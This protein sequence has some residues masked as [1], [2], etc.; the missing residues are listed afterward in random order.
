MVFSRTIW[1]GKIISTLATVLSYTVRLSLY[2][3]LCLTIK[4]VKLK[5]R[6]LPELRIPNS[7][8]QITF[9][10]DFWEL[11]NRSVKV[12]PSRRDLAGSNPANCNDFIFIYSLKF[13]L[14]EKKRTLDYYHN[15]LK[16]ASEWP[17]LCT[18]NIIA[19]NWKRLKYCT[20]NVKWI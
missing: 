13:S 7:R 8:I 2:I 4:I 16:N 18:I 17:V 14:L 5:S 1:W 9:S 10:D 3:W 15:R 12:G 6:T 20:C 11:N 19:Y